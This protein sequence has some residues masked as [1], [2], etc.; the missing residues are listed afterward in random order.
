MAAAL[1]AC[2]NEQDAIR[3]AQEVASRGRM[4]LNQAVEQALW[5]AVDMTGRDRMAVIAH[6]Y[7][8][9]G[10]L[11]QRHR[12]NLDTVLVLAEAESNQS[13]L[14]LAV[15]A[16][17][18]QVA[19]DAEIARNRLLAGATA[20]LNAGAPQRIEEVLAP[21]SPVEVLSTQ[22]IPRKLL[23]EPVNYRGLQRTM[24]S[25]LGAS[26]LTW[27]TDYIESLPYPVPT[28]SGLPDA[29]QWANGTRNI[30]EI[31]RSV[32]H[33]HGWA[34]PVE[35]LHRFFEDL[36]EAGLAAWSHTGT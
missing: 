9:M 25:R 26:R 29:L 28:A 6:A 7:D 14:K 24:E 2:A 12:M 30:W 15:E 33:E 21:S 20:W 1:I 19:A 11:A 10:Y 8:S 27:M 36:V 16:L 23:A 32:L 4:R 3:F 18:A 22:L 35:V 17:G 5:Q 31:R 13:T 34:P